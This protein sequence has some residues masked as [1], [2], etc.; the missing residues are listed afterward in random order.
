MEILERK[1]LLVIGVHWDSRDHPALL[2]H[3]VHLVALLEAR[4]VLLALLVH[5]GH[6]APE[7][8]SETT[9]V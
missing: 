2:D 5:L 4:L 3:L 1:G 8:P 6:P 7:V 9:N